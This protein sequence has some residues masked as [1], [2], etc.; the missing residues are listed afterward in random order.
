MRPGT[1]EQV[2]AFV[3]PVALLL[4]GCFTS[5]LIDHTDWK[6][7]HFF[8]GLD[9]TIYFLA[10]CLV[11]ILD[12]SREKEQPANGYLWTVILIAAA[13]LCLF[14]QTAVHQD[15]ETDEKKGRKQTIMLVVVSNLIGLLLLY[16][17]IRLKLNGAI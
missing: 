12:I 5:K 3:I 11:N 1:V 15:W 9:L 10:T 17:F 14:F 8:V 6:T 2:A 7:K 4:L 13:L 16:A